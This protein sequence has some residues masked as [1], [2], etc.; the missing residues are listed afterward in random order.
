[1]MINITECQQ[2]PA[3]GLTVLGG[4]RK[5]KHLDKGTFGGY[6]CKLGHKIDYTPRIS[7]DNITCTD[8]EIARYA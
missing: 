1:M 2:Y 7:K 8:K 4:R 6:V 3:R 5:C